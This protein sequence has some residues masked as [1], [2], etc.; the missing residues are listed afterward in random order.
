MDRLRVTVDEGMVL[1]LFGCAELEMVVVCGDLEWKWAFVWV[2]KLLSS[3]WGIQGV[4]YSRGVFDQLM[5]ELRNRG[6]R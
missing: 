4:S 5:E 2:S 6:D 3:T 1:R